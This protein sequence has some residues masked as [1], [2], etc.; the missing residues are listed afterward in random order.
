MAFVFSPGSI[1]RA[2]G[3]EWIV[4]SDSTDEMLR[5]RPVSGSDEDE[6][7]IYVPLELEPVEPATFAPPK[8][9]QIGG[10]ENAVLLRDALTL[11]LRRGAGP[12]RS[13]GQIAVEPRAYQLVPLLMALK[14]DPVRLLIAD[15]VGIGKTIEAALILR[16][17]IDRG[18]VSSFSVL[19]PPH[20]VEQWCDE[21]ENRFHLRPIAVT[22]VSARKL[23]R[24]LP[25]G[26][27][28]F[29]TYPHT[30][31]SLDYIK[32]D[33]R[34]EEFVMACPKFVIVDEAHT[35]TIHGSGR[36]QRYALLKRLSEDQERHL[37][38]LTATPHSG[39]VNAFYHLLA[40]LKPEFGQMQDMDE[41][42]RQKL[43]N[44]VLLHHFVQRRR[45][46]ID[47]WKDNA[48]FPKRETADVTYRLKGEY[49]KF[50]DDILDYCTNIVSEAGNDEA[51][52]RRSFF[53]T[54]ALL[55]CAS[56]SPA[57]ALSAL[58]ARKTTDA[59]SNMGDLS[60]TET[61]FD[62]FEN[63]VMDK[64]PEIAAIDDL[65][66]EIV[67][68][69]RLSKLIDKAKELTKG[70]D[71]TKFKCLQSQLKKLLEDGF[72]P[73]V[74]CRY[75]ATVQYL[76]DR[77]QNMKVKNV[78]I[79]CV[80]GLMAPEDRRTMIETLEFEYK[81]G[82]TPILVATDCLS[83]G[84]NLQ[85]CFNAVIHYDL[86]WNPTRHEQREGRVDRFGQPDHLV[87][88]MMIY[89]ENNPVDGAVLD[90]ILRKAKEIQRELGVPV[91]VP[92]NTESLA[93]TLMQ[94]V[95]IKR[96]GSSQ[97]KQMVFEFAKKADE[98][99]QNWKDAYQNA[100]KN[101]TIFAQRMIKPAEVL[102]E[103]NKSLAAL[104]TQE[105]VER[106]TKRAMA[107][108]NCTPKSIQ[109]KLYQCPLSAMPLEIAER[110]E[111]EG[112]RGSS[113]AIDFDFPAHAKALPIRRSHPLVSVLAE[114]ML[115]HSL[116][117]TDMNIPD[118][119]ALGRVGAW[120]ADGI[121]KMVTVVLAR[122]RHQLT[123][124]KPK[125]SSTLIVEEAISLAWIGKK[126][127]ID[128]LDVI[129]QLQKNAIEDLLPHV[130]NRKI[131]EAL[132]F[133]EEHKADIDDYARKRADILLED[134]KHVREMSNTRF[135][136]RISYKVQPLLPVDII[137]VFVMMPKN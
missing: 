43:R 58:Q 119:V 116:S 105:D 95:L 87:R 52:K 115:E 46:D 75:I 5:C 57:A 62:E 129:Q 91:P 41:A 121:D 112:I 49:Q 107:Y 122:C 39:D 56:S 55:R 12:F 15:D 132:K 96:G 34:R 113:V 11:S 128:G 37:L 86:S 118:A 80:T 50:F 97:A 83:E 68:D 108:L 44:E 20:L 123:I 8:H 64:E 101:K 130:R 61:D 33:K 35:C 23:E 76:T 98:F 71:D 106:F 30:V 93:N 84:I 103:F 78:N 114:S 31:V 53:G 63:R 72:R 54:L 135:T 3:R 32:T 90:V 25:S 126:T 45:V 9:E 59:T 10:H 69:N 18:D 36:H 60:E 134:H 7:A 109:A 67:N 24:G 1:V 133:V 73:V 65:E 88:A 104:G 136:S 102:P 4:L 120:V 111:A 16:E 29:K 40:L 94:A 127:L 28:L 27:S 74:F 92:G 124:Q 89:G 17:L 19:C 13:F 51:K 48:I 38:L 137:G 79:Y 6:M 82:K 110:L 77:L 2:R 100:K 14:I 117:H 70:T 66:P 26:E 131:E 85:N 125:D 47:E 22:D 21:L 99:E 81:E 42:E